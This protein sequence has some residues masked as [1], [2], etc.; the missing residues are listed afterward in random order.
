MDAARLQLHARPNVSIGLVNK[1]VRHLH[2]EAF[3]EN[4][5]DGGF[6]LRAPLELLTA[7]R[8]AYRFDRHQRR[9]YFTLL[10][11]RRLHRSPGKA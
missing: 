5:P 9:S 2:D 11:G 7:W 4:L 8:E 6:K 1:V 3:I 10:Q